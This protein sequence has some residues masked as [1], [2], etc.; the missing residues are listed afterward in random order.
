MFTTSTGEAADVAVRLEHP[1][2]KVRQL[3]V[4]VNNEGVGQLYRPD[5]APPEP[6]ELL[7]RVPRAMLVK[8]LQ[9]L[10]REKVEH[11]PD[12]LYRLEVLY[13][14][15]VDDNGDGGP[16]RF[17]VARDPTR[18]DDLHIRRGRVWYGPAEPPPL[19]VREPAGDQGLRLDTIG[20]QA[21]G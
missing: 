6:R 14:V 10:G 20:P 8:R 3:L 18:P 19:T 5:L 12:T 13:L 2:K 9:H 16:V 7:P 17:K 1:A 21:L 11:V 15:A 4:P